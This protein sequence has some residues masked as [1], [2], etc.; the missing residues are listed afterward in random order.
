MN[1]PNNMNSQTNKPTSPSKSL[2]EELLKSIDTEK[3]DD[4]NKS[5]MNVLQEQGES[6]FIKHVFT[7][8]SGRALTY[9]E[10]RERYG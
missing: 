6:A 10:M 3:M 9:A 5:A 7:D 2:K 8:E 1:T 4:H